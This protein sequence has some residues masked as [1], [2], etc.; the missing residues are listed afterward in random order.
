MVHEQDWP[1]RLLYPHRKADPLA[2]LTRTLS[3]LNASKVHSFVV[4]STV[5]Q[6][7]TK[8]HA[9]AL[10]FRFLLSFFI[11]PLF[12]LRCANACGSLTASWFR[13]S[14]RPSRRSRVVLRMFSHT[15]EK[16][17]VPILD[18]TKSRTSVASCLSSTVG[19]VLCL[20]KGGMAHGL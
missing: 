19:S 13:A 7:E 6:T 20:V 8:T 11:S 2:V 9:K 4:S 1:H 10:T 12:S 5:H 15:C 14:L 18:W 3:L 17:V 16:S